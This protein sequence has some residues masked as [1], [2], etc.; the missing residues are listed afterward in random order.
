VY[1]FLD[2]LDAGEARL[3]QMF[4]STD[5]LDADIRITDPDVFVVLPA[6]SDT[7]SDYESYAGAQVNVYARFYNMGTEAP[8]GDVLVYLKDETDNLMLDT[9]RVSFSGL[10]TGSCYQ[11]DRDEAVFE[12]RPDSTDIG[13]HRLLVYTESL[14]EPDPHDNEARLVYVVEPRDYATEI[15]SNPWDMTESSPPITS[16]PWKTF[17]IDSLTGYWGSYTDSISGMFEGTLTHPDS[18]NG[19]YLNVG[20]GSSD[21]IDADLYNTFSM[22]GYSSDAEVN[23]R[24]HWT[25]RDSNSYY[26]NTGESLTSPAG[27][28]GSVDLSSLSNDWTSMV[29]SIWLEFYGT[30]LPTDIRIGWIRLN[31]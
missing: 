1:Q 7:L 18:S 22:Y 6:D 4:D 17:D 10:S 3:I 19:L 9:A 13:V 31:E 16:P 12:W 30:N 27:E 23:I 14:N 2:T 24:V 25:D 29:S 11:Q 28:T 5:G 20:S 26:V 21:W 8:Q 15:L